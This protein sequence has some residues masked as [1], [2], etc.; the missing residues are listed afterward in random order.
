MVMRL[1]EVAAG[2]F[3]EMAAKTDELPAESR[4]LRPGSDGPARRLLIRREAELRRCGRTPRCAGRSAAE[5]G[6]SEECRQR[7]AHLRRTREAR[8]DNEEGPTAD[9]EMPEAAEVAEPRGR[10]KFDEPNQG[11]RMMNRAPGGG[12]PPRRSM[13]MTSRSLGASP[14]SQLS[15]PSPRGGK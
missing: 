3:P 14:S 4:D 12:R 9:L 2:G 5:R 6:H 1:D 15:Q 13:K 10:D 7:A 8:G 11:V